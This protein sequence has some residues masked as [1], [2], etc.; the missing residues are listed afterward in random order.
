MVEKVKE[1]YKAPRDSGQGLDCQAAGDGVT[2]QSFKDECDINNI[3]KK[4][5]QTGELPISFMQ[6]EQQFG[7]FSEVPTYQEACE[8]VLK[9]NNAF[10]SLPTEVRKRFNNDVNQF[11]E[12]MENPENVDEMIKLGLAIKREP[13]L[14]PEDKK[15]EAEKKP[16]QKVEEKK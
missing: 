10:E 11:M 3:M 6:R 15:A 5:E 9:A 1:K 12:F 2:K 14:K 7:D 13:E 4:Y 16:E 8:V